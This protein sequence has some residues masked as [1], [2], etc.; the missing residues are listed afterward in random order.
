M[1][2]SLDILK[3]TFDQEEER[4]SELENGT[5][6]IAESENRKKKED[7]SQGPGAFSGAF[8]LPFEE[9]LATIFLKI[10]QKLDEAE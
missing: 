4:I 3:V 6:T 7:K 9:M 5:V 8:Y 1:K 2:I 10:F